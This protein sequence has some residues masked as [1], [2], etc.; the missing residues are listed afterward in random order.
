M[1]TN[2][3]A[4]LRSIAVACWTAAALPVAGHAFGDRATG[5]YGELG[6]TAFDHS[7]T[8][9]LSVGALLPWAPLESLR[10]GPLSV[11]WDLFLSGWHARPQPGGPT[12][13]L[14]AGALLTGRY[15]FGE[16]QSPWFAEA[17]IGG[18]VLNHLYKTPPDRDFST[19]FQFTEV[20][21]VGRSFGTRGEHEVSLRF[22]HVSNGGIKR[23]NWGE[24]FLRARYSYRF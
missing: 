3:K 16:G 9:S 10:E 12:N 20:I 11:Y 4:L 24:N 2:N 13:Y 6:Y 19:A 17:G 22:Q 5:I 21:G 23:P 14:Q 18:S 7:D 1:T 15:R 8:T